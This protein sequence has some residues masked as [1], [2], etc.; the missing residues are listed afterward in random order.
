MSEE[1]NWYLF[2]FRL[3]CQ[4]IAS[5]INVEDVRLIYLDFALTRH[6]VFIKKGFNV[7]ISELFPLI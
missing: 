1:I 3:L 7:I 6:D 4:V 5:T 2:I